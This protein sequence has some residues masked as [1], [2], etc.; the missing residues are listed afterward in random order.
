MPGVERIGEYRWEWYGCP[1]CEDPD[2]DNY[3]FTFLACD[4]FDKYADERGAYCPICGNFTSLR[5][6][7]KWLRRNDPETLRRIRRECREMREEGY[8]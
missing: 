1:V 4:L 8:Y 2:A 5:D 7:R 3:G 6:V